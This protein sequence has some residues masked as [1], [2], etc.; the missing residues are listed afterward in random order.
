M[1]S[2]LIP[3]DE[4]HL[5]SPDEL[6]MEAEQEPNVRLLNHYAQVIGTLKK[7]GFTF[8]RIADWLKERG[9]Q[10]DHNAVWRVYSKH[11]RPDQAEDAAKED[12]ELEIQEALDEEEGSK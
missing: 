8:R 9:V 12:D 10:A 5:P 6:L 4:D 3:E 7:K 2:Y 11:M 1:N